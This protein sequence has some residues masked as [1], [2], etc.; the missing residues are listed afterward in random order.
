MAGTV[1]RPLINTIQDIRV[2]R[3]LPGKTGHFDEPLECTFKYV[4]LAD[5][6][7]V[8]A[9]SYTWGD[10]L[11]HED[12]PASKMIAKNHVGASPSI[13]NTIDG[14]PVKIVESVRIPPNLPLLDGKLQFSDPAAKPMEL[15]DLLQTFRKFE[16]RD[17][18]DKVYGLVGLS[19][20]YQKQLAIDY[21][22]DVSEIHKDVARLI[23][24]TTQRLE[25][26]CTDEKAAFD[27]RQGLQEKPS[28][29]PIWIPNWSCIREGTA[30]CPGLL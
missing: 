16:C 19:T 27:C 4:S 5:K 9:L 12:Y 28:S 6:P 13:S 25:N 15:L 21:S 7:D 24:E 3:I 11:Y 20:Q 22:K 2:L 10:V 1:Y 18:R 14:V 8:A 26:I 30:L 29:L 17:P 23:I